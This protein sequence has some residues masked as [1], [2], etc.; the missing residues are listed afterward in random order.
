MSEEDERSLA[1]SHPFEARLKLLKTLGLNEAIIDFTRKSLEDPYNHQS[2]MYYLESTIKELVHSSTNKDCLI[3]LRLIFEEGRAR[4][5]HMYLSQ[6]NLLEYE[7]LEY[8]ICLYIECVNDRMNN[9][10][11]TGN[12]ENK[13]RLSWSQSAQ[14]NT[15]NGRRISCDEKSFK[16]LP[17]FIETNTMFP[18]SKED[19]CYWYHGTRTINANHI[20]DRGIQ[21]GYGKPRQDFSNS[22]GFYLNPSF[23]DAA[24]W[25]QKKFGY[26]KDQVAVLIYKFS[27]KQF[28]GVDLRNERTKWEVVVRYY[29]QATHF[30]IDPSIKTELQEA[31]YIIG[32]ISAGGPR[33]Q[34]DENWMPTPLNKQYQLCIID[35]SLAECVSISLERIIYINL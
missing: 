35:E 4:D 34:D 32:Q 14:V 15:A 26:F 18:L 10:K 30:N 6:E 7:S 29:R 23:M 28:R 25:A 27:F 33:Y 2:G 3:I 31:T 13:Q 22:K 1:T 24:R 11:T 19:D 9:K 21:L 16:D 8:W 17:L 5:F 12:N 20:R